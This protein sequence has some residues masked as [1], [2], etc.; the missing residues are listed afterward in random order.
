MTIDKDLRRFWSKVDRGGPPPVGRPELGHCWLWQAGMRGRKY[1]QF[2][3]NGKVYPAHRWI[4]ITIHGPIADDIDVCHSCD[5]TE[6][7]NP[8]HLF[9]GSRSDNMQDCARK[10]RNAMQRRPERSALHWVKKRAVGEAQWMA[11]LTVPIVI[12][13]R[14]RR[15]AGE[16]SAAIGRAFGINPGHVRR[17]VTGKS[18]AHV[19]MPSSVKDPK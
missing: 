15:R 11:K 3:S 5:V 12:E 19:P 2:F 18:W 7:V 14:N 6:C 8:D 17:V 4:Y 16:T 1:G 13:M 9:A 10:G